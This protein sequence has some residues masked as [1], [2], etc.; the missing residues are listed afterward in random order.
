[1]QGESSFIEFLIWRNSTMRLTVECVFPEDRNKTL[2]EK[3]SANCF[4]RK[5]NMLNLGQII[6]VN[7]ANLYCVGRVSGQEW[8]L[9]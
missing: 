5:W 1:M 6:R 8:R 9:Q 7:Q 4:N 3:E 2:S